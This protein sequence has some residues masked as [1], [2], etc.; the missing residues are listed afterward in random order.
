MFSGEPVTQ[1]ILVANV[2]NTHAQLHL[3]SGRTRKP[4]AVACLAYVVT[5]LISTYVTNEQ[6]SYDAVR[7]HAT[8]L[9]RDLST[10]TQQYLAVLTPATYL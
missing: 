5:A 4:M 2:I 10:H 3:T 1:V 9:H 7:T 8:Q 6:H